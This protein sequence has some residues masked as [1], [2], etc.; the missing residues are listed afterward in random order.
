METIHTHKQ[1]QAHDCS[2]AGSPSP[3]RQRGATLLEAVAFLGIAAIILVGA[4]AL[5]SSAFDGARSNQLIE[6]VNAL[7]TGIRKVYSGGAGYAANVASGG[8]KGLIDAGVVPAT[9]TVIGPNVTNE[10][11][12]AVTISYDATN[13]AMEI[14]FASVP[15]AACMLA[16]TTSSGNWSALGTAVAPLSAPPITAR[17]AETNCADPSS[18]TVAWEFAS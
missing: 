15:R 16:M 7:Q 18:N 1:T 10:W 6:E 12:G 9:L 3:K 17:T 2:P 8:T 4:L 5:F 11:G 13:N 14:Q